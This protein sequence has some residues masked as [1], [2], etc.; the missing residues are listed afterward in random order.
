MTGVSLTVLLVGALSFGIWAFSS[1]QDYKNNVDEKIAA[2][3]KV[4]VDK[5]SSAKDNQFA[6]EAKQPLKT[7][8]TPTTFGS[9]VIK[10]P[11]TWSAYVDE[12]GSDNPI[13]GY[14]HPNFVPGL[15]SNTTFALR[16]QVVSNAY[17]DELGQFKDNGSDVSIRP[18]RAPKV[19]GTLG[20]RIQGQIAENKQGTLILLPLRDKTLKIWTESNQYSADLD[21][22]I[23]PNLTFSP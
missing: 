17:S 5:N 9:V 20:V 1:R 14:F 18:Y 7:Y 19:R 15:Q 6:E 2:A 12:S 22:F 13:D 23:L 4:A 10:Y 21:K 3:V 8:I 16:L 11:R